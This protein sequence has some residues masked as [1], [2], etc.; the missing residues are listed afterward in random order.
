MNSHFAQVVENRFFFALIVTLVQ[1]LPVQSKHSLSKLFN[2]E[3][4]LDNFG[5]IL[6]VIILRVQFSGQGPL[7]LRNAVS[8]QCAWVSFDL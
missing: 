5:F 7:E 8:P 2:T 6:S 3:N 4:N 1:P